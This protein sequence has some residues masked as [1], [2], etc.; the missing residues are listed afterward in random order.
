M[1]T[2]RSIVRIG[3]ATLEVTQPRSP[4]YKINATF[5]RP[6][7]IDRFQRSGRS[8]FYLAPVEEGEIGE[9]DSIEVLSSEKNAPAISD[10]IEST[11]DHTLG[12]TGVARR[13]SIESVP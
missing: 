7:M 8:G 10:L 13:R 3:T 5:G 2:S 6:D 11:N 12:A 9:G 4:C 1:L